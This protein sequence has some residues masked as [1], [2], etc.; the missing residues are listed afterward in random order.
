MSRTDDNGVIIAL[1]ESIA[2]TMSDIKER[3]DPPDDDDDCRDQCGHHD[4]AEVAG[5]TYMGNSVADWHG[6]ANYYRILID[7]CWEVLK[8]HGFQP[9]GVTMIDV[10]IERMLSQTPAAEVCEHCELPHGFHLRSCS[11]RP[12]EGAPAPAVTACTEE[13]KK[14]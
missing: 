7:R 12:L 3:L 14:P 2:N 8:R 6:K 11:T 10:A 13:R 4:P 1:L 9:N 5:L